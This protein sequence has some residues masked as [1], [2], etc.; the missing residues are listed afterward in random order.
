M[1]K[2]GNGLVDCTKFLVYADCFSI[3]GDNFFE[4][5]AI[6]YYDWLITAPMAVLGASVSK[7]NGLEKS[8]S[9]KTGASV[10]AF[11]RLSKARVV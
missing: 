10:M 11:L 4:K 6:G 3:C 2:L 1:L 9:T 7:M 8:G 5:K